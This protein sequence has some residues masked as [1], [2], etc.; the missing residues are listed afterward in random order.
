MVAVSHQG[1]IKIPS[2]LLGA[3]GMKPG[4]EVEIEQQG[5]ALIIRLTKSGKH[6][7]VEDGPKILDYQGSAV[8]LAEMD[9]AIAKGAG[10]SV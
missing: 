4:S 2:H 7:Q 8:T 3:L 6:S 9:E 10:E 1:E 5:D